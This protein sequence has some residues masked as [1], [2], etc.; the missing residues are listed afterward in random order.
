MK[1]INW[2]DSINELELNDINNCLKN[3]GHI[4]FPTETVY[5]IGAMATSN[6]AVLKIFDIKGRAGDNPL[7]V[8][9][10]NVDEINK[11]AYISNNIEKKL[12]NNFMPGPFTLILK[13]KDIIPNSV[14]ANLDTVGIRIPSNYIANKILSYENIP[15]AAPSANLSG[16]PS[17]TSVSNIIDDFKDK[18]DYIID[19]GDSLIGLE[20]T[21][22]KVID[23]IPVI[24]RPGYIT[25]EDILSVIG[26]VR[27]DNNVFKKDVKKAISPGMK[28]RHYAPKSKCRLIYFEDKNELLDYFIKNTNS[29]T[30]IIGSSILKS[31]NCKKY[32]YYGD[33]LTDIAHNIFSLLREADLYNPK[34]ILIEG[35]EY[36]GLGLAIMNRLL[37][38][39][40]YDYIS[41]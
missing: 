21:V 38:A 2:K 12:I 34:I 3:D 8:H 22:V 17:G 26:I 35:V 36:D 27:V 39:C 29:D 31:I 15:I 9:L 4:I 1:I 24:L 10:S 37:R 6:D 41:R 13:K 40:S 33:K 30:V 7:I 28:Y 19:G 5:G 16:K 11:Y 14:S 32:L 20:S 18:V 23:N 25:K